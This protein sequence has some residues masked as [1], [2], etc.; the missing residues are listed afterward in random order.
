MVSCERCRGETRQHV[1]EWGEQRGR[2][3]VTTGR[4][5][6]GQADLPMRDPIGE[7]KGVEGE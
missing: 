7:K 1:H 3:E 4:Q 5:E 6:L 2:K